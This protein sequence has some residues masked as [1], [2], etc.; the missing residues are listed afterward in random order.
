MS[1]ALGVSWQNSKA[2]RGDLSAV[3]SCVV[4]HDER[5][6][7]TR[8]PTAFV[9]ARWVDICDVYELESVPMANFEREADSV[10]LTC[11]SIQ[12]TGLEVIASVSK[13]AGITQEATS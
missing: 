4:I 6:H 10:Q 12:I 11:A 8:A 9:W 13:Q 5:G 1:V 2:V 7:L 3:L